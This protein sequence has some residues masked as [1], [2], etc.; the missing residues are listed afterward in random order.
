MTPVLR[1]ISLS[2]GVVMPA[3]GLGTWKMGE[4][5]SERATEV[6]AL[7]LGLA[8]G[9]TLIDTAEMYGD[10]GAEAVVGEAIDGIRERVFLVSKVYPHNASRR[11]ALAACERSLRR[12]G[13]DYLDLYLLHWRGEVPLAQTV[14]AFEAL[15]ADG[16]I[17]AWGV[18]N[19]DVADM[20]ELL[21]LPGGGQCVAN[22]VLYHLACRGV[23]WDLLPFCAQRGIAVMAYSPLGRGR[24]LRHRVLQSVASRVGATAA[25]VAL[26]WLLARPGVAVIPKAAEPGHV[27]QNA[28][29]GELKLPPAALAV[30]E[31]AFPAPT[32][33]TALSML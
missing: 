8:V 25:Q 30:L 9:I 1:R 16:K 28:A 33:P 17:R 19:F 24:L 6:A 13:T 10:G 31:G 27:R 18:S 3:V 12:L 11:G 20:D 4:R 5:R 23:E 7:K 14:A 2:S 22:Q 15:R 29:A 26:A 21:G 32:G